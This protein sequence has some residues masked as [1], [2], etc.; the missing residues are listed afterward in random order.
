M[1]LTFI[2]LGIVG[3]IFVGFFIW[4]LVSPY[5]LAWEY[6]K[7]QCGFLQTFG[8]KSSAFINTGCAFVSAGKI[9]TDTDIS[10]YCQKQCASNIGQNALIFTNYGT[11][12]D[13][14]VKTLAPIQYCTNCAHVVCQT[15]P[16]GYAPAPY[17]SGCILNCQT[18]NCPIINCPAK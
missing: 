13:I 6:T 7:L 3:I 15:C 11:C 5:S 18:G 12:V 9:Y 17:Q 2:A 4:F 16:G 10:N 14:C 8:A 1:E